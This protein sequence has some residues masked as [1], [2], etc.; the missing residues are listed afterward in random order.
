MKILVVGAGI[1]GPT[2]AFWLTKG[3]HEVTIVEHA[4]ELRTGGY[5][6]DFWGAG[7]EVADR[8]GIVPHLRERGYVFTEA[9]AVDRNGR[10]IAGFN[11][12]AV[13]ESNER[14]VSIPRT[15]LAEAIFDA[16][17]GEVELILG[18]SVRELDDDGERVRVT[19]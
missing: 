9:R 7:F 17:N 10:K 5:L 16:L 14:Y 13:M 1:A 18:D 3:G 8:M 4:P 2:A 19:F 11:P 6:I 15:D 12:D